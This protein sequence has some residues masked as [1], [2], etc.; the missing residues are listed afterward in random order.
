MKNENIKEKEKGYLYPQF[1]CRVGGLPTNDVECLKFKK[2]K[3]ICSEYLSAIKALNKLK[4]SLSNEM[5]SLIEKNNDKQDRSK[6]L[7]IRRNILS[8]KK[9]KKTEVLVKYNLNS[10]IENYELSLKKISETKEIFNKSYDEEKEIIRN[11]FKVLI[12]DIDFQKGLLISSKPLFEQQKYYI[13]AKKYERKAEQ[14]ERGLLRYFTRTAMKATPFGT[15]CSIIPGNLTDTNRSDPFYFKGDPQIK[16]SLLLINKDIYGI[17]SKY[18]KTD[19]LL[20]KELNLEL[21]KTIEK[22]ET[23]YYFLTELEGKEIFQKVD[24]N[25]ILEIIESEIEK[26]GLLKYNNLLTIL[27]ANE[28]LEATENEIIVYLDKLIEIGFL[29]F[30]I[31]I[32]EQMVDWVTPLCEIL[33]T[34][35]CQKAITLKNLIIE[36]KCLI[37]KYDHAPVTARKMILEEMSSL[38]ENS[39][40]ELNIANVVRKNIP[41]YEDATS[42]SVALIANDNMVRIKHNLCNFIRITRSIAYPRTEH[43]NMR[44]FYE[45]NYSNNGKKVDLLRFYEDYYREHL[46]AHLEKQHKAQYN[47]NAEDIKNYNLYNPFNIELIKKIQESRTKITTLISDKWKKR[48]DAEEISI[49]TEELKS[50][51]E[52][53]PDDNICSASMFAQ[54]VIEGNNS[55]NL[56]LLL[57][58]GR[59]HNGFGKYF[60]RFLN[61]FDTNVLKDVYDTNNSVEGEFLAEISGDANFN[62]NLHPPLLKYEISYPTTEVGMAEIPLKCT[63]LEVEADKI[64]S[65]KLRLKHMPSNSYVIPFDL[66]FLNPMMRPPLFQLLSKFSPPCNFSLPLP[67]FPLP[68]NTIKSNDKETEQNRANKENVDHKLPAEEMAGKIVYRPRILFEGNIVVSRKRWLV[69]M[70]IFPQ[71]KNDESDFDFFIRVNQWI[72]DNGMPDDVYV[73]IRP[74]PPQNSHRETEQKLDP[75]INN[76]ITKKDIV[77]EN[78]NSNNEREVIRNEKITEIN[79]VKTKT[80]K[81]TVNQQQANNNKTQNKISRDYYKPQYIDFSNPLLM[82]LFGKM[83][84]GLKNFT[85]VIEERYP[86]KSQLPV[87]NGKTFSTEQIF[88]VNFFNTKD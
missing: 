52:I 75:A 84:V 64:D 44:Y 18:L 24:I 79:E 85:A 55:G 31:G 39:F 82:N 3:D 50:A 23:I 51:I 34:I 19:S 46:K 38:I 22:R 27:A 40:N 20:K 47:K 11:K 71:I 41:L 30:K 65:N 87:Y 48:I 42:E 61:L 69:P 77:V 58:E 56:K 43:A 45:N 72:N 14:I 57:P 70:T 37:D 59:Y 78:I 35:N 53:T 25:P 1:I 10:K 16:T 21:N 62:A 67:E 29:R 73:R 4:D 2:T 28:E 15:L 74:L 54:I 66:G 9:I 7:D 60:S 6:L 80:N 49:T 76:E 32:P 83:T 63:E 13:S 5:F 88:Q 12:T 86:A 36:L 8:L 17:I 68:N 33:E 26:E 81:E